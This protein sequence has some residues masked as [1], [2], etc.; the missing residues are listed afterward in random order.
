MNKIEFAIRDC[1]EHIKNL[2]NEKMILNAELDAFK[3]QLGNLER[4]RDNKSI[5]HDDQ[6][7]PVT[8]T[9]SVD[10]LEMLNTTSL[11][12]SR[13]NLTTKNEGDDK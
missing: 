4:I 11:P 1:E 13:W 9:T 12:G 8:L 5:P 7:K 2:Q 3:K 6:H 10:Q